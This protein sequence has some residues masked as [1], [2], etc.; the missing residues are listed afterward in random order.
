MI[1]L[2][3][4]LVAAAVIATALAGSHWKAYVSGKNTVRAEWNIVKIE[5]ANAALA[6]SEANRQRERDLQGAKDVAIAEAKKRENAH[7]RDAAGAR[8]ELERLSTLLAGQSGR[9]CLSFPPVGPPVEYTDP[10][11]ELLL[12]CSRRLTDVS[13]AADGH[14]SDARTLTEAWPK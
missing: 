9:V 1:G 10:A 6:A 11:R 7:R 2:Y 13:A 3:G 4:K 14:A 8:G 5:Q 12:D